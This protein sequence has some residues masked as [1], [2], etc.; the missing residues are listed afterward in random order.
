[1][2]RRTPTRPDTSITQ[3]YNS[4]VV[5]ICTVHNSASHGDLPREILKPRHELR[6]EERRLGIQ[7]FYR[8]MAEQV[9]IE[10]VIRC[11]FLEDVTSQDMAVA[12]DGR[13]YG[14]HMIQLAEGVWPRS[15]DLTLTAVEQ[16]FEVEHDPAG[17]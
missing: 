4:G 5:S 8:G 6:F 14:I 10:R 15:M 11:P 16:K 3:Q 13:Q 9:K 17:I 7:R 2:P 1:M 12:S